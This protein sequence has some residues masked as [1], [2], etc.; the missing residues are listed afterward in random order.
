[1]TAIDRV[2]MFLIDKDG[3]IVRQWTGRMDKK[4]LEKGISELLK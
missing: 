2:A 4:D 1:M 3:R